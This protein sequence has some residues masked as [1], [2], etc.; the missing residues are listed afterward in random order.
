MRLEPAD[1]LDRLLDAPGRSLQEELA[2][3]QRSVESA[4]AEGPVRHRR[5]RVEHGGCLAFLAMPAAYRVSGHSLPASCQDLPSVAMDG[6]M[7]ISTSCISRMVRAPSA[8]I[9]WRRAP[10]RFCVPWVVSAGP[11]RICSSGSRSPIL[12][13]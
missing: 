12:M 4:R 5:R 2:C 6:A 9:D 8:A 11:N 10:A 13:R 7:T 3:Q 1:L